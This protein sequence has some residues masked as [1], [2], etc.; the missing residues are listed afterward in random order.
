MDINQACSN[1][2]VV[3][4]SRVSTLYIVANCKINRSLPNFLPVPLRRWQIHAHWKPRVSD[5]LAWSLER[6]PALAR[7]LLAGLPTR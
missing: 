1:K 4:N 2:H 6:V 3:H 5:A 7:R